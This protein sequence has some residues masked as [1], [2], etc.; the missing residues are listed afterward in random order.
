VFSAAPT[1]KIL[2]CNHKISLLNLPGKLRA[3]ILKDVLC[4]FLGVVNDQILS[5]YDDVSVYVISELPRS[6]HE[7]SWGRIK[8][9]FR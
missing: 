5:L 9:C 4:E 8:K 3:E 6:S 1:A 7:L 2:P